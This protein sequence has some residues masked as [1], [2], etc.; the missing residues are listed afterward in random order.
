MTLS[1]IIIQRIGFFMYKLINNILP[2]AMNYQIVRNNDI[3]HY[4]TRQNQHLRGSRPHANQLYS[5]L[6]IEV[7]KY[8]I[9][10]HIDESVTIDFVLNI[11]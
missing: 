10:Y 5:V 7:F 3:H 9:L 6:L 4:N 8:G 11:I 2:N 1:K